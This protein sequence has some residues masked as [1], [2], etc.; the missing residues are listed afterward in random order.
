ML[1]S[2]QAKKRLCNESSRYGNA[3][4]K[5]DT[6]NQRHRAIDTSLCQR[7]E[8]EH[9]GGQR[10]TGGVHFSAGINIFLKEVI[11]GLR[12]LGLR[13]EILSA[14]EANS[15][16]DFLK[17]PSHYMCA[18]EEDAGILISNKALD[19]FHKLFTKRGGKIIECCQV[20]KITPGDQLV[21]LTTTRGEYKTKK[22]VITAG[23]WSSKMVKPLGLDL[24]INVVK[25]DVLYWK[26]DQL[27]V[28][29]PGR[30]DSNR[31]MGAFI[32]HDF[33]HYYGLPAYEYPGLVKVCFHDGCTVDPDARDAKPNPQS[34]ERV[35]QFI[36]KFL[37]GVSTDPSIVESCMYSITPDKSFLLGHHPKHHNI[38]IGAGFSG[39][40]FKLAPVVG[41]IL[42]ELVLDL[43]PSYNLEPFKLDRFDK[44]HRSRL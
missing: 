16:F 25:I 24:P 32:C 41:K 27:D 6:A 11:S 44:H 30:G 5:H 13:H 9:K 43:P 4:E 1:R 42:S 23:P 17:L 38:I 40:G 8:L 33:D 31:S 36:D 22:L 26:V 15:R 20:T 29:T 21:T 7:K 37:K 12:N 39:H 35:S 2:L 18:I 3:G 28:F 10:K 14:A 19:A 34:V